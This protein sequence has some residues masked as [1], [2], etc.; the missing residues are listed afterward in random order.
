MHDWIAKLLSNPDLCRMGHAQRVADLNLGL[1]WIYYALAR[2]LKPKTV[3][4]IGSFRGFVPLIFGKA[5]NDNLEKGII[6]FIDP[7]LVDD[8]WKDPRA[9]SAYFANFGVE[10]IRHH[11]MT[12]QEFVASDACNGLGPVDI[13][14]VDGYHSAE[15]V[16]FDFEA[17]AHRLTP[18]GIVLFHDS[19]TAITSSIYGADRAYEHQ[20]KQFIDTLRADTRLQ[21]F[22]LPFGQGVTLVR[23]A[24]IS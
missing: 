21:V 2:V 11:L 1:G 9:V 3:V 5:L 18:N 16:R 17:F 8:F 4:V 6:H 23:N 19:T 22:D 10:N 14:F 12:T 15:Q 20:V 7:S 24:P 13:A